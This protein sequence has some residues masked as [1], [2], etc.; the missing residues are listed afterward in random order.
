[1]YTNSVVVAY[2]LNTGSED[3][4]AYEVLGLLWPADRHALSILM[5]VHSDS[6][7]LISPGAGSSRYI[8]ARML[9]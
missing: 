5:V 8:A 3:V 9:S 4:G 6:G 7:V 1:M 2:D